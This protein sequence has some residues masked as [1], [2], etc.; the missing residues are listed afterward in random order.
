MRLRRPI[1]KS[2]YGIIHSQLP[3]F[4][5]RRFRR[6]SANCRLAIWPLHFI[7]RFFYIPDFAAPRA[8]CLRGNLSSSQPIRM[9]P[10]K[11]LY[12]SREL[13]LPVITGTEHE[14]A[15]DISKLRAATGLI[16]MDDGYM[17][18][19]STTS[20]ITFLDGEKGVLRYRGYPIEELA[21]RSDF[22]E[23]SYLLIYGELP[24]KRAVASFPPF[25]AKAHDAARGNEVVLRRLPTRRPSDG[26][27]FERGRRA[28][29]V[30]S[31]FAR[32]ARSAAGR[33]LCPPP[34]GQAAHDRQ[35]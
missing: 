11:L 25:A 3:A 4:A 14:S 23:T 9:T 18:T 8:P 10:A 34:D 22:V 32:S 27:S 21:Q 31:R 19:G 6:Q 16:T 15:V 33:N 26:N 2:L 12:D 20:S 28:L 5:G 1:I 35:L 24:N 17:N 13:E 30:L 7:Y 29:H